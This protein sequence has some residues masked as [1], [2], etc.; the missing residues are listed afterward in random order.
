MFRQQATTVQLPFQRAGSFAAN[1]T[2]NRR[3]RWAEGFYIIEQ[4]I[5]TARFLG[6]CIS[7]LQ[8]VR[9]GVK[10]LMFFC[11]R[12]DGRIHF[13]VQLLHNRRQI[14]RHSE[15][16]RVLGRKPQV[17]Q[18]RRSKPCCFGASDIRRQH[19]VTLLACLFD[20]LVV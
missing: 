11:E 16:S 9:I 14:A 8:L 18:V 2:V 5:A 20:H 12:E 19:T 4:C 13:A 10:W 15:S 3:N 7:W 1:G 17:L 6:L